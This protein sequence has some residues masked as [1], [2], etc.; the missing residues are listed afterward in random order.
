LIHLD[1]TPQK[2][3]IRST[4]Q[5]V[6]HETYENSPGQ[7]LVITHLLDVLFTQILR[8]CLDS[9]D[10]AMV[11]LLGA[12]RDPDLGPTVRAVL[13]D[14][15]HPWQL[16]ELASISGLSRATFAERFARV[17]GESPMA[18]VRMERLRRAQALLE[19]SLLSVKEI[20]NQVGFSGAEVFIRSFEKTFGCSP[21]RYRKKMQEGG[22]Y[23]DA[24]GAAG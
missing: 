18:F 2:T 19:S 20:S 21:S 9:S 14:I 6:E 8:W 13:Q 12:I 10:C 22:S 3:W 24:L 4:L 16:P 5:L 23:L 1:D 17:V 15:R 7:E 11:G